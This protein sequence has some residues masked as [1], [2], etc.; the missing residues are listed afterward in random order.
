M[1]IKSTSKPLRQAGIYAV[2]VAVSV[3]LTLGSLR[4]FPQLLPSTPVADNSTTSDRIIL[5]L[6]LSSVWEMQ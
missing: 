5:L 4:A 6:R 1:T 3:A 2:I